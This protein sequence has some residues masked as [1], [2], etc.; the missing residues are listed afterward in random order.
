VNPPGSQGSFRRHSRPAPRP[1]SG[2]RPDTSHPCKD[3]WLERRKHRSRSRRRRCTP[4]PRG[5]ARGRR[6]RNRPPA[7]RRSERRRRTR[8]RHT[9]SLHSAPTCSPLAHCRPRRART[10]WGRPPR[11]RQWAHDH[12]ALHRCN[13]ERPLGSR[14]QGRVSLRTCSGLRLPR[15]RSGSFR[16]DIAAKPRNRRFRCNSLRQS[17]SL[18]G[19]FRR[20]RRPSSRG[21]VPRWA[22]SRP[23]SKCRR[24][25]AARSRIKHAEGPWPAASRGALCVWS[26]RSRGLTTCSLGGG[27]VGALAALQPFAAKSRRKIQ[28]AQ[29]ACAAREQIPV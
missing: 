19:H 12:F 5:T 26:S 29:R 27:S 14:A 24:W 10:G 9:T 28:P 2:L 3:V 13:S 7:R 20:Q 21:P 8:E 15:R 17:T 11:N 22:R 25:R 4:C 1:R 23:A 18:W 6:G 16:S